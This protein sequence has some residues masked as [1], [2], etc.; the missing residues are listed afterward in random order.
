MIFFLALTIE[1]LAPGKKK[2]RNLESG[3]L[4]NVP[5]GE[6]KYGQIL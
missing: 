6:Q 1:I 4:T 2:K 3:T 5:R